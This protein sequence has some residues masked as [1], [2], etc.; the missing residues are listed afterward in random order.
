MNEKEKKRQ[1]QHQHHQQQPAIAHTT[2]HTLRN[3]TTT[4]TTT[5][6]I[7]TH[8]IHSNRIERETQT[9]RVKKKKYSKRIN[10]YIFSNGVYKIT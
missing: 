9:P 1:Q 5:S 3:A 8:R 6:T 4:T 7:L 10:V 2:H